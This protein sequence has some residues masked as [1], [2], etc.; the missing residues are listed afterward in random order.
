MR[1]H[2][3]CRHLDISIFNF[4]FQK[5][6]QFFYSIRSFL[7]KLLFFIVIYHNT[8]LP[9]DNVRP[10]IC[11]KFDQSGNYLATGMVALDSHQVKVQSITSSQASLNTSFTLEKSNKLVNLAWIPSDSIQLLALCLSK[12]SIFDIFYSNK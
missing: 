6:I 11:S 1:R 8:P 9:K 7:K 5:L 2:F 10:I 4:F 12:G 3:F